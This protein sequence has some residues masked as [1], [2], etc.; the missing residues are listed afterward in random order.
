MVIE[1]LLL[2]CDT[3]FPIGGLEPRIWNHRPVQTMRF[4]QFYLQYNK[5]TYHTCTYT[6]I[7]FAWYIT[8]FTC[9]PQVVWTDRQ[10]TLLTFDTSRII[11]NDRI[12]I[13]RPSERDWNLIIHDVKHADSGLYLCQMN[14]RPIKV[15]K[16]QLFVPGKNCIE[17]LYYELNIPG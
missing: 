4:P 5:I 16:V 11:D 15:K 1:C 2:F 7:C 8:S 12:G 13:D 6:N 10:S 9:I 3:D 17:S 14:T